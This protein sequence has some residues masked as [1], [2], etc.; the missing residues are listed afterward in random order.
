M[1]I[2]IAGGAGYIGSRLAPHLVNLGHDVSVVDLLWF[3]NALPPEIPVIKKDIFHLAINDLKGFDRVIFMAGLSNDPMADYSPSL[4]F[5]YN[6]AA[7]THLAYISKKAGVPRFIYASSCSVY[8]YTDELVTENSIAESNF[9]YGISKF[10]GELLTDRLR[11]KNFSVICLRQGT[12]SGYSPRMRFDLLVNTMYSHAFLK[13][14]I[15]V[16]SSAIWRPILAIEDV[17]DVY[18]KVIIAADGVSGIFNVCSEN[19]TIGQVAERMAKHFKDTHNMIIEI[20]SKNIEDFRNYRASNKKARE[21]LG[22]KFS[23]SVESILR[24]LD[25]SVGRNF[26]FH[27]DNHY[28]IKIFKKIFPTDTFYIS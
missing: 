21:V 9:P 11:D 3:G 24:E 22:I 15:T 16:N 17:V 2:L 10:Q 28:N 25:K 20:E 19:V 6:V 8:G 26:D 1:K 12:V 14:K 5:I 23:G 7:P 18:H 27:N 13:N 4:N